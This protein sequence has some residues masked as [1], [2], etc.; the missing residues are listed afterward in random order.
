MTKAF[1]EIYNLNEGL[2]L[3]KPEKTLPLKFPPS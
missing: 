1:K 2:I 3:G